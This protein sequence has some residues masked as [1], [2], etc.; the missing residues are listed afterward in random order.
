MGLVQPPVVYMQHLFNSILRYIVKIALKTYFSKIQVYGKAHI[1]KNN[2]VILV[3]NHQNALI[4]PILLATH[5]NLKPYFL[6]RTSVFKKASVARM[7]RF[8]RM[9]PVYRVR[10]GIANMEK[11]K[12]TFEQ[13][14]KVLNASG[15]LIIFGEGNHHHH[16]N[17]RPIRKGFARIAFQSLEEKPDLD[18]LILPVGINYANP[19]RS[20]SKVSIRFGPPLSPKSFYP[21]HDT[22]VKAVQASLLPLVTNIPEDGYADKVD[23]LISEKIDLTDPQAVSAAL[24]D[25][26]QQK[27]SFYN[28]PYFTNKVMKIFHFPIFFF[29]I[30]TAPK[31]KDPAFIATWKFIFGLVGVPIWYFMLFFVLPYLGFGTWAYSWGILAFFYLLANRSGQA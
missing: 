18:L 11:N 6:T 30:K 5:T 13:C 15:S 26:H 2:P 16:R 4:D 23:M 3:G 24:E 1:P 21:H 9:I 17:L 27:K 19:H 8:I 12:E 14:V 29:W 31:I 25:N 7:L 28:P 20:G 10:D 22:L